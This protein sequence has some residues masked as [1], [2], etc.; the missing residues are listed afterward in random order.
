MVKCRKLEMKYT[1]TVQAM[2][3]A[4]GSCQATAMQCGQ[5]LAGNVEDIF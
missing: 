3:R 4:H 2:M 1:L 5:W